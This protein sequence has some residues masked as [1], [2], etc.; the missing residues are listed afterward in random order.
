[1]QVDLTTNLTKKL[2]LST[3]IV[4]SP[5]DTVTEAEMAI[6][7]AMVFALV[8]LVVLL[9]FAQALYYSNASA[10]LCA[11]EPTCLRRWVDW[12]LSTTI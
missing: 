10:Y 5:M 7:M 11:D 6:T 4:S 2:R 3:P 1:M 8:L 12:V 9:L